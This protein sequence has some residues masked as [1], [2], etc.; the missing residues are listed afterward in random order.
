MELPNPTN[1]VLGGVQ[2][3]LE[4]NL[5][6][7]AEHLFNRFQHLFVWGLVP[8]GCRVRKTVTH[9]STMSIPTG[10]HPGTSHCA[11]ITHVCALGQNGYP[12]HWC[13]AGPVP[14]DNR[15]VVKDG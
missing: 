8:G 10:I 7:R 2:F 4:G 3:S 12:S 1:D 11:G 6:Q 5:T 15:L 13:T 9:R 14:Q